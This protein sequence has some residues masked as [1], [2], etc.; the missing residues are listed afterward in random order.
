GIVTRHV[1]PS[2]LQLQTAP[3]TKESGRRSRVAKGRG[4]PPK[5]VPSPDSFEAKYPHIASWVQDGW[6]EIGSTDWSR[7]FLRAMDLGGLVWEGK[8]HYPSL[9][10]ALRAL[11]AGIAE[12]LR[13]QTGR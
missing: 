8:E 13:G 11:D 2:K 6:V 7:S 10:E 12:W 4:R 1:D 9:E 3:T 5:T